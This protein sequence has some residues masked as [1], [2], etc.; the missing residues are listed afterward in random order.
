MPIYKKALK[1]A[2]F[3]KEKGVDYLKIILLLLVITGIIFKLMLLISICSILLV[4]YI[5]YCIERQYKLNIND[6]NYLPDGTHIIYIQ[7]VSPKVIINLKNGKRDGFYTQYFKDGIHIKFQVQ[8]S[9]GKRDGVYTQ[10]FEDGIQIQFQNQYSNGKFNGLRKEFYDNGQIK[11][12][13]TWKNGIQEGKSYYY[14]NDGSLIRESD[15]ING[16]YYNECIEY[17]KNGKI[18]F[19]NNGNKFIF[20]KWNN[21]FTNKIKVC[22][23]NYDY[24][25]R[26]F[27]GIWKNY[28]A[29]GEIDYELDFNNA[30]II[31]KKYNYNQ[32]WNIIGYKV[33]K[34]IYNSNG[35]EEASLY[36]YIRDYFRRD[37]IDSEFSFYRFNDIEYYEPSGIKGPPGFNGRHIKIKPVINIDDLIEFKEEYDFEENELSD[38]D[39]IRFVSKNNLNTVGYSES[40]IVKNSNID[41]EEVVINFK[42]EIDSVNTDKSENRG[43]VNDS[44][45]DDLKKIIL[46]F[47]QRISENEED[48]LLYWYD[49]IKKRAALPNSQSIE[50]LIWGH[51]E[52]YNSRLKGG[53][54][55]NNGAK[56]NKKEK[57]IFI[58]TRIIAFGK[59]FEY[60]SDLEA[61]INN[62]LK[63]YNNNINPIKEKLD[64]E[65]LHT[66]ASLYGAIK[67]AK[68]IGIT[69]SKIIEWYSGFEDDSDLINGQN[70]FERL[71]NVFNQ[72][73][74]YN[75]TAYHYYDNLQFSEGITSV[76]KALDLIPNY[77]T[78]LDTLAYGYYLAGDLEKALNVSQSCIDLDIKNKHER[79][80]H[81]ITRGKIYLKLGD[82]EKA[83]K[84]INKA[85]EIDPES[86]EA[87][88]LLNE[89]K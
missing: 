80:E 45:N 64:L 89:K 73:N 69:N 54:V 60:L 6:E 61:E 12:Q 20:F 8:Y 65:L 82:D 2:I 86:N 66:K 75:D 28:N 57:I 23:I 29:N 19:I 1:Y 3:P 32:K 13:S 70:P 59:L 18:K 37:Q 83:I 48:D 50:E 26:E 11:I 55:Y 43:H 71:L 87:K 58:K 52:E 46:N 25:K 35:E 76:M 14:N 39:S 85:I 21:D 38:D 68:S 53:D 44:F 33:K 36:V 31:E 79:A 62:L 17:N 67:F 7:H 56:F 49:I 74:K 22:E 10:Y 88:N 42:Q 84:D 27:I 9:N 4:L 16:D 15:I 41:N 72:A 24:L 77:S 5:S 78:Y 30:I 51:A 63:L 34:I 81:Y 47:H 40:D